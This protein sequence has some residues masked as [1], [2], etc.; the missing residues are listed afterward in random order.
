MSSVESENEYQTIKHQR[1]TV[2]E[3]ASLD[4]EFEPLTYQITVTVFHVSLA[5][6]VWLHMDTWNIFFLVDG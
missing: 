2:F 4:Y 5:V 1:M 6:N 3:I